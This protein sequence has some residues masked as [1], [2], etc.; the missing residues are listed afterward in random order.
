MP[1]VTNPPIRSSETIGSSGGEAAARAYQ[2]AA[3]CLV[4]SG[5]KEAAIRLV[6]NRFNGPEFATAADLQGR[7]VRADA[8]LMAITFLKP[9]D[10]RLLPAARQLRAALLD[11]SAPATSAAQR[12]F[13]IRLM[14]RM[15]LPAARPA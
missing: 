13:L 12:V 3:R 10:L 6:L 5:D 1:F 2:A 7:R 14:P 15:K 11:Y 8:L 9:G 4:Q